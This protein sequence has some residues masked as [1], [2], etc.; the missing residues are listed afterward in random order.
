MAT[1]VHPVLT[2]IREADRLIV[3]E[4][5]EPL[6]DHYTEDAVLIV[7]PG[8]EVRG[9]RAI[10]EA[11]EKMCDAEDLSLLIAPKRYCTDN[12]A[13]VASLAYYK[14]KEGQFADLTL[15]PKATSD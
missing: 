13:M 8:V 10:R 5:F 15:E 11:M 4:A 1:P 9:R 3:A 6:M 2:R 14:Y 7:K 12:A